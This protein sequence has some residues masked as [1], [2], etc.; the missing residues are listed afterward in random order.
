V[1]LIHRDVKPSNIFAS[2]R[3]GI[4][5]FAKLLDFGLVRPSR[6]DRVPALSGEGQILGTPLFMSPEQVMGG[7]E[8]DQRSDLYSLGAV[9]YF[10]LTSR[11][12]FDRDDGIAAMVAHARDPVVPP[13]QL[14][15]GIPEDLE[16]I[17]LR[18]LAKIPEDR[19][20]DAERLEEAMSECAC[21]DAWD[22][23]QA[24][25]WWTESAGRK[26]ADRAVQASAG[27]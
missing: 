25:A 6:S 11:P 27:L 8:L 5:D 22:Q 2:R 18:C 4:D 1:G 3:G 17:V 12:P 21:A 15:P 10:L 16:R 26:P 23:R 24:A 14:R 19:F 9:A 13:S 7:R 20:L